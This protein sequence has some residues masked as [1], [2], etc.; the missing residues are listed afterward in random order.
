MRTMKNSSLKVVGMYPWPGTKRTTL[1]VELLEHP[2]TYKS[3][4]GEK[5]YSKSKQNMPW[6]VE[7]VLV[8][9]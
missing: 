3:L 1:I 7:H 8:F 5:G 4:T 9:Q 6:N 2:L